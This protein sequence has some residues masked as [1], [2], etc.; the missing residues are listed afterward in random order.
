MT[1]SSRPDAPISDRNDKKIKNRNTAQF[2]PIRR[3][4]RESKQF[5]TTGTQPINTR[6]VKRLIWCVPITP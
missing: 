5:V 1:A 2:M 4:T 3:A 6:R